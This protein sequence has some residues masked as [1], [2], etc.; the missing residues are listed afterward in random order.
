[1]TRSETLQER[2]EDALFSLL[3]EDVAQEMGAQA[4]EENERLKSD[5]SAAMPDALR[6]KCM[7]V[8]RHGSR[9]RRS[10]SAGRTTMRMATRV[11]VIVMVLILSLTVV[12]AISPAVR[13]SAVR[14]VMKTHPDHTEFSFTSND[15][16][17]RTQADPGSDT[18]RI[19]YQM[20][21]NWV[22]D[23][24]ELVD[25]GEDAF[26]SWLTFQS[27]SRRIFISTVSMEDSSVSLNRQGM[28]PSFEVVQ[29]NA[30][31]ALVS[32]ARQT[33]YVPLDEEGNCLMLDGEGTEW[34]DL[35][36]VANNLEM[37]HQKI[38][39]ESSLAEKTEEENVIL[40]VTANWV[41]EGLTLVNSGQDGFG[42]W[43]QFQD[44]RRDVTI[45]AANVGGS[46]VK[47]DTED[48]ELSFEMIRGRFALIVSKGI[49]QTI[50]IPF[51]E[52]GEN[53][54]LYGE[55]VTGEELRRVAENL[56]L[57]YVVYQHN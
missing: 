20:T 11:A 43:L 39:Q 14:W 5:P 57:E 9:K 31:L 19:R 56:T 24:F 51:Q 21:A 8:V 30:A 15:N 12:L 38:E 42:S 50:V 10:R 25:S 55:Q 45:D 7:K 41:P 29:G 36:R 23:G 13:S 18:E 37:N 49:Y 27:G 54:I 47:I 4:L 35:L 53:I 48:A 46:T 33:I 28:E 6:R 26:G 44:G 40:Q 34:E 17:G 22:P 32:E 52:T 1:M 2:Y 3:M 16:Q